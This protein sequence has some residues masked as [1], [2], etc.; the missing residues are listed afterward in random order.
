[1]AQPDWDKQIADATARIE[2]N[3]KDAG[4]FLERGRAYGKKGEF[5]REIADY[6]KAIELEPDFAGAYNNRGLAYSNKGELDK[7]IADFDKAIELEPDLPQPHRNRAIVL[8]QRATQQQIAEFERKAQKQQEEHK[9]AL[10]DA[11]S[12]NEELQRQI[13]LSELEDKR[14]QKKAGEESQV[15][16]SGEMIKITLMPEKNVDLEKFANFISALNRDYRRWL[17]SQGENPDNEELKLYI[18]KI[19]SGSLILWLKT[20]GES[21]VNSLKDY[22]VSLFIKKIGGL[23]K[24]PEEVKELTKPDAKNMRDMIINNIGNKIEVSVFKKDESQTINFNFTDEQFERVLKALDS[25]IILDESLTKDNKNLNKDVAIRF[26]SFDFN[27]NTNAK[28]IVDDVDSGHSYVAIMRDEVREP[29]L[30]EHNNI[31]KKDYLADIVVK[32]N[33]EGAIQRYIIKKIT[34]F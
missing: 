11:L 2:Q 10:E 23:L 13:N 7:A 4:A 28:I 33:S 19:E 32:R 15:N 25:H 27:K 31:L 29:L 3:A 14:Q 30:R 12:R 34:G 9:K 20:K 18:H 8:A 5:A 21:A 16:E 22:G 1:M 17:V 26:T 24:K 6:D